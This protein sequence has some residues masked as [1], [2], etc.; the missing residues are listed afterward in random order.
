MYPDTEI[1]KILNFV[2]DI[3]EFQKFSL[4]FQQFS[5]ILHTLTFPTRKIHTSSVFRSQVIDL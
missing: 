2:Q 4:K 3:R 1:S 5:Q